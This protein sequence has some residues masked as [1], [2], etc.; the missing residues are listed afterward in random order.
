MV[1]S[2]ETNKEIIEAL[3]EREPVE[4]ERHCITLSR[5]AILERNL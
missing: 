5:S 2:G 1:S 3:A 4:Q